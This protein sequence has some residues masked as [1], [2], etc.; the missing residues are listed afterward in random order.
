MTLTVSTFELALDG[1]ENDTDS[2]K[3]RMYVLLT[4][5]LI[6]LAHNRTVL[7]ELTLHTYS[8]CSSAHWKFRLTFPSRYQWWGWKRTVACPSQTQSDTHYGRWSWWSD[9]WEI[10]SFLQ[11][12]QT[13]RCLLW[14]KETRNQKYSTQ[15]ILHKHGT[16]EEDTWLQGKH[17]T[18]VK[19]ERKAESTYKGCTYMQWLYARTYIVCT[20]AEPAHVHV[21]AYL[22]V[23]V[24]CIPGCTGWVHTWMYRLSAYLDVQVECIP[25]CTG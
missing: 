17:M 6:W 5:V 25:G 3:V 8:T 15:K 22:D 13:S 24:E 11:V 18:Q 4:K 2:K 23:Q 12:P 20:D 10:L 21:S 1:T 16:Q 9:R 14:T 19:V 7:T